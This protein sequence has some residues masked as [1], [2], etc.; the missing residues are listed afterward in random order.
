MT[1]NMMHLLP[2]TFRFQLSSA[3]TICVSPFA[4]SSNWPCELQKRRQFFICA[5]DATRSIAIHVNLWNQKKLSCVWIFH[6]GP[7]RKISDIDILVLFR[8]IRTRDHTSPAWDRNC[9]GQ[10]SFCFFYIGG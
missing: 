9:I 5:H 4:S 7:G 10:T 3:K 6:D 1:A 2:L 8:Q